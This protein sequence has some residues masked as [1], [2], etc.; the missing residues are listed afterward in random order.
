MLR[1]C[2]DGPCDSDGLRAWDA[3][4]AIGLVRIE[5]IRAELPATAAR[6]Q[7]RDRSR[8]EVARTEKRREELLAGRWLL[9]S[10]SRHLGLASVLFDTAET[11]AGL[12]ASSCPSG[13]PQFTAS[14]THAGG[15]VACA[16]AGGSPVGIDL[17]PLVERDFAALS[18]AAF[19]AQSAVRDSPAPADPQ[20]DFY[21]RWTSHEARLKHGEPC[22]PCASWSWPG[23]W[24]LSLCAAPAG[25]MLD[26]EI[27]LWN[28][29][30]CRFEPLKLE[31]LDA[32]QVT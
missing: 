7:P 32:R 17:E 6:L 15:W 27:W 9:Q 12:V 8:L 20:T 26:A 22:G 19:P 14:I 4:P 24:V 11:G 1:S 13:A 10:F 30:A 3:A 18:A 31:R 5:T 16:L 23:Q 29:V 2:S 28:E 21:R 25:A